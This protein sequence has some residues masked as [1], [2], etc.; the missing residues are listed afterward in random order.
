M[1]DHSPAVSRALQGAARDW[2]L[3]E[4]GRPLLAAVSGGA[5]SMAL[6]H[7]L[8]RLPPPAGSPLLVAHVNHGIRGP[9]AD[10]D[11]AFVRAQCRRLRV[12]YFEK[13]ADVPALAEARGLS[14]EMAAREVRY[15]F[16]GQVLAEAGA[17]GVVTAHTADDQA[18]TVLLRLLRGAGP[19]GLGAMLPRSRVQGVPV[20]RPFLAVTRGEVETYLKGLGKRWREDRTNADPA[21]LR[22]RVRHE[23]LPLLEERFSPGIREILRRTSDILREEEE[24]LLP[25][26]EKALARLA[27]ARARGSLRAAGLDPLPRALSRRVI[28]LW[29]MREGLAEEYLDFDLAGRLESLRGTPEGSSS[30]EAGGGWRVV[31]EYGV[32]RLE[33]PRGAGSGGAPGEALLAAP[34]DTRLPAWGLRIRIRLARGFDRT[35]PPGPGAV[36]C[37][38]W[39]DAAVLERGPLRVRS[40]K[41]GD[42]IALPAG[43]RKLQDLFM[44]AKA[45][46]ARRPFIPVLVSPQEI[47]W[48]AGGPVAVAARVPG[49]AAPSLRV[50]V[51]PL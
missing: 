1:K 18:E 2:P 13:K 11:A 29:L 31:S 43:R 50:D 26:A 39:L 21:M 7:G 46:R 6:L 41:A 48:V 51:E 9:E 28:R 44:D 35:P 14:L 49:P 25:P 36:P 27:P 45:P 38:A 30:A 40:W 42:R 22:N 20:L 17:S 16:F 5:D 19:R 24:W 8:A 4:E 47:L 12:P 15:A 10:R 32:W 33:P 3:F 23:L 37:R 34:G